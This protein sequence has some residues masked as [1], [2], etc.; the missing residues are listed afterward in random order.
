M[1]GLINA[2]EST[3]DET[4]D[5]HKI[6]FL[7]QLKLKEESDFDSYLYLYYSDQKSAQLICSIKLKQRPAK[8]AYN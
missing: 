2:N 4:Y 5:V 7:K 8:F 3:I 6:I 1:L